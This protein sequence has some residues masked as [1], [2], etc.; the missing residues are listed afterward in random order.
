VIREVGKPFGVESVT[1]FV[2]GGGPR[3]WFSI[4][5]EQ[6]QSNYAQLVI[7]LEDKHETSQLIQPLQAALSAR[8]PGARIDVRELESGPAVGVPVSIR[9]SGA[10]I[11]TLRQIAAKVENVLRKTPNAERVRE[12]WGA[13]NFT[14]DVRV[15]ADRASAAG[16]THHDVSR[17]SSAALN[18]TQVG[19]LHEGDHKLGIV[20]RLRASERQRLADVGNLYVYSQQSASAKAPLRQIAELGFD[21]RI[22]KILRRNHARTITIGA[23]PASGVLPSEVIAQVAPEL[24]AIARSLPPGY[25]LTIGGEQEEQKKSF[26]ELAVVLVISIIA[27]FMALVLQFKNALK[28]LLVFA[29]IPFG[30][31]AGLAG[32]LVMG[33]PFGFMAFLGV[34]SLIGVIVSHVIV[35]FDFIE[36]RREQGA[37]LL[38]ALLDAGVLR[39][40]P[41]LV[42][43]G[44]TVLGLVPLAMHGGPLWEPLCFVQIAGLTVATVVTLVLVPV[45]YAMFV[46]DLKLLRWEAP[47]QMEAQA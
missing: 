2:G 38:E 44:A 31:V 22:A 12:N 37:P 35:L 10:D 27:I 16:L 4:A 9:V 36:E 45:F 43:V 5:P 3:F 40:R 17:S 29:A 34:I 14:V 6:R 26:K 7:R 39:L 20:A 25:E 30:A 33:A 18:G 46:L 24:D 42:T 8:I 13:D 21:G 28:P 23:F 41:V 15:D 47:V 1:T 32:L 11:D 19:V